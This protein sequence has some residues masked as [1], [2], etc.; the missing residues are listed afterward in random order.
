MDQNR[1]KLLAVDGKKY[2]SYL[3]DD[4]LRIVNDLCYHAQM[5]AIEGS[6]EGRDITNAVQ[7]VMEEKEQQVVLEEREYQ[8]SLA[9]EKQAEKRAGYINASI[10]LYVVVFF[11]IFIACALILFQK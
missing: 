5:A 4:T 8:R 11:G 10:L 1:R 6:E 3:N 9:R 7:N 2:E